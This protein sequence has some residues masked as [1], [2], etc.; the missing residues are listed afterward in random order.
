MTTGEVIRKLRIENK[1][2]QNELAIMLG[3]KL[4]TLQKYESGAIQNLKLE[5]L[6]ELCHI[7]DVPP[8][9]FVFPTLEKEMEKAFI[10]WFVNVGGGLNDEGAKK[11]MEYIADLQCNPKY[12]GSR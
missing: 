2:T 10:K 11:V 5:T 8:I 1:Y 4:S 6:R 12:N 3:L 9:A 7:F